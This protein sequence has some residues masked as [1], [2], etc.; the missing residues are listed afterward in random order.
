MS[1]LPLDS[2]VWTDSG[3]PPEH[4][5]GSFVSQSTY[6]EMTAYPN[7]T[8]FGPPTIVIMSLTTSA[9]AQLIILCT[10]LLTYQ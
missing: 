10:C 8:E 2:R 3:S 9:F 6:D 1:S 5:T 7:L 4:F